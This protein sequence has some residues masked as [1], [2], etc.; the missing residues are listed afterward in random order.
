MFPKSE[1]SEPGKGGQPETFS[2]FSNE[3][4]LVNVV[5]PS[6]FGTDLCRR[7]GRIPEVPGSHE[8]ALA[9]A[10]REPERRF[11]VRRFGELVGGSV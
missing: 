7:L 9:L 8:K 5:R 2:S 10:W 4:R 1:A 3:W 6:F 11:I